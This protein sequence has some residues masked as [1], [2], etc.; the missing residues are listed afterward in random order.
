V[1]IRRRVLVSGRVQGVFFRDSCRKVAREEGV[2]G[3]AS[4]LPDGRVEV[5]IEGEP[6]AVERVIAWCRKGTRSAHVTSVDVTEEEPR[7]ESS[8]SV[9]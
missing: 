4:N 9:D 2:G 3:R 7:G 8:F 1:S 6:E 5:V